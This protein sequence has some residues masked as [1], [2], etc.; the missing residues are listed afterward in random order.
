MV[1]LPPVDTKQLNKKSGQVKT[2][3]PIRTNKKGGSGLGY[4]GHLW[5][6]LIQLRVHV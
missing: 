5:S 2:N 6:D 3:F 1:Q 4:M